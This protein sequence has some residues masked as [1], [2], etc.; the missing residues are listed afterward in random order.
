M[1][2][3]F[4]IEFG[5]TFHFHHI[6]QKDPITITIY[7][8]MDLPKPPS[9]PAISAWLPKCAIITDQRNDFQKR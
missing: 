8:K 6:E 2:T 1:V 4:N 3:G 7:H 5:V 9:E